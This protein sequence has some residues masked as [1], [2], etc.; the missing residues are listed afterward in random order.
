MKTKFKITIEADLNYHGVKNTKKVEKAIND[1]LIEFAT[2]QEEWTPIPVLYDR[3]GEITVGHNAD[4]KI[5]V[6]IEREDKVFF[7]KEWDEIGNPYG[8]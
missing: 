5:K 6:I 2:H 7:Q 3:V 1:W 4:A 8:D